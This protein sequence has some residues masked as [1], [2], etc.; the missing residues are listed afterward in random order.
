MKYWLCT[1][2]MHCV[3]H[4]IGANLQVFTDVVPFLLAATF[5]RIFGHSAKS[6]GVSSAQSARSSDCS[7][8]TRF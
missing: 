2:A 8:K 7:N 3:G 5:Y 4:D 6:T 1:G